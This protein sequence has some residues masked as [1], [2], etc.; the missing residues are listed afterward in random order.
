MLGVQLEGAFVEA[1]RGDAPSLEL[2]EEAQPGAEQVVEV[3]DAERRERIGVERGGLAAAQ[4]RDQSLLEKP[5]ARLVQHPKRARHPNEVR[6]LVEQAGADAVERADPSAV[7]DLGAE[8][9]TAGKQLFGDARAELVGGALVEGDGEDL[10][11]RHAML[12][13][14]AEPLGRGRGLAR[15]RPGGDEKRAFGSGMRGR[16][17]LGAQPSSRLGDHSGGAP[18]YGQI[19]ACGHDPKRVMQVPARSRGAGSKWPPLMRLI[20]CST[21][22]RLRSRSPASSTFSRYSFRP[23]GRPTVKMSCRIEPQ[24]QSFGYHSERNRGWKPSGF[25]SL[26][27]PHLQATRESANLRS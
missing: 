12:D 7:E 26:S 2:E 11:R 20:A 10:P 15:A 13:E 25:S 23:A 8:L 21:M 24:T 17:L 9:G 18:P 22:S 6:E 5:L 3:V 4:A 16:R 14:P 1:L 19:A 27:K